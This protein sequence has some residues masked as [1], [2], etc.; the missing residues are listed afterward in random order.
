VHADLAR[1]R[2]LRDVG[3][4]FRDEEVGGGLDR[5][6]DSARDRDAHLHRQWGSLRERGE[7]RFKA[8]F[9]EDGG[10]NAAGQI[11]QFPEAAF[12]LVWRS[13]QHRSRSLEVRLELSVQRAQLKRGRYEPLL[14]AHPSANSR[15]RQTELLAPVRILLARSSTKECSCRMFGASS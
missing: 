2:V 4:C 10:V 6:V 9:G 3:E 11:S 12:E 7:R 15:L 8:A 1:S 14:S 5:R 13:G